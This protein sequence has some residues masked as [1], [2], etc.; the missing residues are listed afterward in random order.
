MPQPKY[1]SATF[2]YDP[3]T[4]AEYLLD[5]PEDPE[6]LATIRW[7][8]QEGDRAGARSYPFVRKV[9]LGKASR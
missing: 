2:E 9:V 4:L 5:H 8:V 6:V 1:P 3:Y 7:L